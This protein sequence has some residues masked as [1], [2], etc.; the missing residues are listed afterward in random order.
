MTYLHVLSEGQPGHLQLLL[1][2]LPQDI[3]RQEDEL[4]LGG[5]QRAQLVVLPLLLPGRTGTLLHFVTFTEIHPVVLTPRLF[6]TLD[7]QINN[8]PVH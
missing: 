6:N 3:Q 5:G 2:V 8:L 1:E 7:N 4:H